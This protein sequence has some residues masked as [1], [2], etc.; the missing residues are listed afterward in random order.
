MASEVI[1]CLT[2]TISAC[3]SFA[4]EVGFIQNL[5]NRSDTDESF[6]AKNART[7]SARMSEAGMFQTPSDRGTVS[8]R[9]SFT[10]RDF[11]NRLLLFRL[12]NWIP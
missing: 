3:V 4:V 11:Y 8:H 5:P 10:G 12:E 9:A 1:S 2:R 6:K 7:T